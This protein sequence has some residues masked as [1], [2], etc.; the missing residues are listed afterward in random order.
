MRNSANTSTSLKNLPLYTML[1]L[2][3]S[4]PLTQTLQ[5]KNVAETPISKEPTSIEQQ[6]TMTPDQFYQK[7]IQKNYDHMD[8]FKKFRQKQRYSPIRDD[9]YKLVVENTIDQYDEKRLRDDMD[10]LVLV[11]GWK[12]VPKTT[13][14]MLAKRLAESERPRPNLWLVAVFQRRIKRARE[15]QELEKKSAELNELLKTLDE[16]NA[17]LKAFSEVFKS[18]RK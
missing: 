5:A 8:L 12:D 9:A 2:W 16:I 13:R 14:D 7:M 10:I 15:I 3:L 4:G 11:L 17:S 1:I 18:R 6:Q